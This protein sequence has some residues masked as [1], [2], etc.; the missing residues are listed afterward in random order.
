MIE[1]LVPTYPYVKKLTNGFKAV[2]S[3]SASLPGIYTSIFQA[4]I[5]IEK[6]L[7][8]GR[9]SKAAKRKAGR[10]CETNV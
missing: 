7:A 3:K 1:E 10:N 8:C 9:A 4:E 5:G 2:L 6:Y